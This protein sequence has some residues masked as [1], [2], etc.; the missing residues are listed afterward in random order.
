MQNM[1][2]A[3]S[4][5]M[6]QWLYFASE[7]IQKKLNFFFKVAIHSVFI[8]VLKSCQSSI[9]SHNILSHSLAGSSS[10][11]DHHCGLTKFVFLNTLRKI[12]RKHTFAY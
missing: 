10:S 2:L 3:V 5:Y 1:E 11:R 6:R 12:Q 8:Y 9:I 7:E 4:G